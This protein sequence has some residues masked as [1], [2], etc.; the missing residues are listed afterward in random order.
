MASWR[1]GSASDSSPEGYPFK[2]GRGHLIFLLRAHLFRRAKIPSMMT[3][4]STAHFW[5]SRQMF[6]ASAPVFCMPVSGQPQCRFFLRNHTLLDR[7]R[8]T[9]DLT[10]SNNVGH[11]GPLPVRGS[12]R[13]FQDSPAKRKPDPHPGR[14]RPLN[15][16]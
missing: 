8:K 9:Q 11:G 6:Q 10:K 7:H 5:C 15:L 1:N 12:Q 4:F 14:Y 2:S 13:D 16:W 3:V